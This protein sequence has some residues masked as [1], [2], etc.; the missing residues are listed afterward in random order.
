[1]AASVSR[2]TGLGDE[3]VVGSLQVGAA[4]DS[5]SVWELGASSLR[6]RFRF[7]SGVRGQGGAAGH[8]PGVAGGPPFTS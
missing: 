6:F 2:A 1:M 5:R 8:R 7:L 3:M 4:L